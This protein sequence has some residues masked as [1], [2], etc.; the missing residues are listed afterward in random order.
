VGALIRKIP[1]QPEITL[2][3]RSGVRGDDR[4]EQRTVVDLAPDL[5]VPDVSTTQLA[6]VEPDFNPGSAEC[7]ANPLGS[8]S[9][10]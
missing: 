5:L 6:L 9:I 10:L 2:M 3:P 4:D 8:L 1:F 7:F